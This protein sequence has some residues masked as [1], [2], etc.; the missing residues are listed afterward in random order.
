M[1]KI[2]HDMKVYLF[3][4]SILI[5]ANIFSQEGISDTIVFKR[6]LFDPL[7]IEK[8]Q[9]C[10]TF[11]LQDLQLNNIGYSIKLDN[12]ILINMDLDSILC[13][14]TDYLKTKAMFFITLMRQGD[15]LY[16]EIIKCFS[17]SDLFDYYK[18]IK[19]AEGYFWDRKI[20]GY[21]KYKDC[22]FVVFE[23]A[24][25]NNPT[26]DDFN[27]FFS[28]TSE[29]KIIFEEKNDLLYLYENPM[30][31]YQYLSD[32][33]VLLRSTNDKGFYTN[34][35]ANNAVKTKKKG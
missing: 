19:S 31:L 29:K 11:Y 32:R 26:V 18:E 6:T 3:I 24:P 17:N 14:I 5:S 8:H 27:L 12:F 16:L 35:P 21:F 9:I 4:V 10:D 22:N 2:K 28:K 25:P 30:W 15:D 1:K 7:G 33:L 23:Y 34:P 13:K 20:Y